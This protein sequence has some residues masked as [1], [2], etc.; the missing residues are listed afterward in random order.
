[1]RRRGAAVNR[2]M[3][4]APRRRPSAGAVGDQRSRRPPARRRSCDERSWR[5]RHAS[6]SRPRPT[7]EHGC[8]AVKTSLRRGGQLSLDLLYFRPARQR[9]TAANISRRI[10]MTPRPT[11]GEEPSAGA[12]CRRNAGRRRPAA[13]GKRPV[14]EAREAG[15]DGGMRVFNGAR[16]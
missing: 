11:A 4:N 13:D 5:R 9:S 3:T 15:R 12:S 6:R 14:E 2:K 8:R 7:A 1:M 16:G 10:G